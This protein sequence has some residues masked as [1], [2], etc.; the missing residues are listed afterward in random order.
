MICGTLNKEKQVLLN[1]IRVTYVLLWI[2]F[3]M[4]G[5][6]HRNEEAYV[7]TVESG[8]QAVPVAGEMELLFNDVDHFISHYGF[9][10]QDTYQ[11]NTEVFLYDR[12]R[13]HMTVDV[14]IDYSNNKV[15]QA[16]EPEFRI[17][18]IIEVYDVD[19]TGDCRGARVGAQKKFDENEWRLVMDNEADFSKI[20]F[21][22]KRNMP[23]PGYKVF[24][25]RIRA[26]RT[27]ISFEQ[28][29]DTKIE[30]R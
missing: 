10:N 20:S 22:L 14:E 8:K 6:Q 15:R 27:Q 30:N 17:F 19:S 24:V 4:T 28:K 23:T 25:K 7:A 9:S 1:S 16:G 21:P 11:W 12:Y 29:N 3:M 2:G 18:E 26:R 5:C 13:L